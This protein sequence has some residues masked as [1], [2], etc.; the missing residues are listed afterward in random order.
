MIDDPNMDIRLL[1]YVSVA[2]SFG[3][4]LKWAKTSIYLAATS[5][6]PRPNSLVFP[7]L[8]SRSLKFW[9]YLVTRISISRSFWKCMEFST[10]DQSWEASSATR[11]VEITRLS[12]IKG[13]RRGH[14]HGCLC[15]LTLCALV[16]F[17]MQHF[18]ASYQL[19]IIA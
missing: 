16:W 4:E 13:L 2:F 10:L 14:L 3:S 6:T 19:K 15:H 5:A 18:S 1:F 12:L 9:N 7:N 17:Q 8:P 11:A